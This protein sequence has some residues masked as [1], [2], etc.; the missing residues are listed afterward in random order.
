MMDPLADAPDFTVE[1]AGGPPVV[2]SDLWRDQ[3]VLLW[4]SRGLACPFCRR[5]MAQFAQ[6]GQ[7]LEAAAT[8]AVQ[9]TPSKLEAAQRLLKLVPVPWAYGCDPSGQIVAAYGLEADRGP[10]RATA[11][12]LLQ[13]SRALGLFLQHPG[14]PHP[15]LLAH[16]K[17]LGAPPPIEGGMVIVGKGGKVRFKQPTGKLA[18]LPSKDQI[19]AAVRDATA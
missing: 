4:F 16:L 19:L 17:E 9:I 12:N 14:E 3:H 7:D 10:L 5:Q 6:M 2:L 18:L 11:D 8:V 15:E 13:Q 1:V